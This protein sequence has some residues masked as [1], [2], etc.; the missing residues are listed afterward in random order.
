MYFDVHL[1][2]WRGVFRRLWAAIKYVAG[3]RCRYG[4]WDEF[5]LSTMDVIRLRSFLEQYLEDIDK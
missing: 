3:Y 2:T 1:S 4:E 5:I